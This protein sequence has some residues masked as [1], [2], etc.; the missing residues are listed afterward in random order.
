MVQLGCDSVDNFARSYLFDPET[1]SF[2]AVVDAL[3]HARTKYGENVISNA[4][5]FDFTT[6]ALQFMLYDKTEPNFIE[7]MR[8]TDQKT[9]FTVFFGLWDILEYATLEYGPASRA[10]EQSIAKLFA[11]LDVL[12]VNA[13]RPVQVVIPRMIDLTFLPWVQSVKYDTQEH[14]AE[15]QHQL[16]F[17][18]KYWNTVLL[19]TA[20]EW[21]NGEVYMPD[22][23]A[24]IMEQV[25]IA[26]LYAREISDASGIGK[27]APLFEEV[28][29]PC[30][31]LDQSANATSLQAVIEKCGD[32]SRYLFW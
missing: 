17:L 28:E 16:V 1:S 25:R 30:L 32:P 26:Q 21:K 12:S 24:M 9:T 14:F 20:K 13:T 7:R 19:R 22:P 6:Q 18:A 4:T 27:Q 29:Q 31:A 5:T 8:K 2:G 23:N 3:L 10:V 15:R 11:T